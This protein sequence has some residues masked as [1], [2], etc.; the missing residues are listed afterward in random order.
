MMWGYLA[1]GDGPAGEAARARARPSVSGPQP[2]DPAFLERPKRPDI[3]GA[4]TGAGEGLPGRECGMMSGMVRASGRCRCIIIGAGRQARRRSTCPLQLRR[5][6][7]LHGG[8]ARPLDQAHLERSGYPEIR[9]D[10]LI[11]R[12]REHA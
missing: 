5:A 1:S 6:G 7:D 9:G 11:A 3:A 2:T 10:E 8:S 4:A 12:C